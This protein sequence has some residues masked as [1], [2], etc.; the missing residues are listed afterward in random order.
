VLQLAPPVGCVQLELQLDAAAG[1]ENVPVG[2]D[3]KNVLLNV[4]V[5]VKNV[6]LKVVGVD[7]DVKNVLLNVEVGV[8]NVLLKLVDVGV[9]NEFENEDVVLEK[10]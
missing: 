10:L 6:L 8:K 2:V 9:K 1:K 3:V 7:V 5:G 4:E